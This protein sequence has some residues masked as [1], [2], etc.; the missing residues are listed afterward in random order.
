MKEKID[1]WV[2]SYPKIRKLLQEIII[3]VFLVAVFVTSV[4]G[5]IETR[6]ERLPEK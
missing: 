5:A 1:L 6:K 4:S 2:H 3:A